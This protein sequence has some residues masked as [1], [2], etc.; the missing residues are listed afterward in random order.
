MNNDFSF[1]FGFDSLPR[2]LK[3]FLNYT[4]IFLDKFYNS[5]SESY[6]NQENNMVIMNNAKN[7]NK[8]IMQNMQNIQ[9]MHNIQN[10]Q[11]IYTQVSNLDN[12]NYNT[13]IYKEFNDNGKIYKEFIDIN[14]GKKNIKKIFPNGET[15]IYHS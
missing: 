11:N 3:Q 1:S 6:V 9:N 12:K 13:H 4:N 8:L 7:I 5:T 10:M 2:K 14:N 15:K